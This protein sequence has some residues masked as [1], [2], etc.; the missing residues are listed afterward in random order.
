MLSPATPRLMSHCLTW[1]EQKQRQEKLLA[2]E[3]EAEKQH[4]EQHK[5]VATLLHKSTSGTGSPMQQVRTQCWM[6]S[7]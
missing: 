1:Q 7:T 6:H 2:E 4:P 5:D 3:I